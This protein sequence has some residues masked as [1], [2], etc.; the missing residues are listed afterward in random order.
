MGR[1]HLGIVIVSIALII[2]LL[3]HRRSLALPDVGLFK[4]FARWHSHGVTAPLWQ[5]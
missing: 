4:P 3:A 1:F 2:A 5:P